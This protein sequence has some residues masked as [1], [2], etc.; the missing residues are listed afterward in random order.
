M[1]HQIDDRAKRKH[2][3][4]EIINETLKTQ[5]LICQNGISDRMKDID[6]KIESL[7]LFLAGE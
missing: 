3:E 2:R 6:D 4:K 7:A 5:D 1:L